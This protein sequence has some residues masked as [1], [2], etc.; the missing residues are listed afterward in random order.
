MYVLYSVSLCCFV[1]FL[2]VNVYLREQLLPGLNPIGVKK[3]Y[4]YINII[5]PKLHTHLYL[6]IALTRRTKM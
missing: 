2:C 3:V 6:R 1:Y 4:Q 5:P